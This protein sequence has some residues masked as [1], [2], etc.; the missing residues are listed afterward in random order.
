MRKALSYIIIAQSL[1]FYSCGND[2]AQ[3]L[4]GGERNSRNWFES[5]PFGMVYIPRGSYIIGSDDDEVMNPGNSSR[6]VT[7]ESFWMDDTEITNNEYRQ[8]VFWVRDSI[9]RNLLGHSFPEYLI[10]QDAVGVPLDEP[11]INWNEG[12]NWN[13]AETQAALDE[14]YIPEN[15]RFAFGKEIDSRKLIYEYS[16]VDY[17]QAARR[18][19]SYN[20]EK[21]QYEGTVT[22]QQGQTIPIANRSAFIMHER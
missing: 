10:S 5:T 8:F 20:F 7:V 1:L 11:R 15:E 17:K 9:A 19:N 12:I 6:R 18:E 14:L 22:D 2:I 4:P 13:D 16:W 3:Y 21:Q